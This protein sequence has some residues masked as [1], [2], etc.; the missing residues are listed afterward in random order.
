MEQA[1]GIILVV[2]DDTASRRLIRTVLG[3]RRYHVE[4]AE[5]LEQARRF[6][7]HTVPALVLLDIR[8]RGSDGLELARDIRNDTRL[9]DVPIIAIT[10]QAMKHDRSRILAAGCDAYVS[11]PVDTRSLPQI[12]DSFLRNGRKL[13]HAQQN[14]V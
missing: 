5:D 14:P 11:K 3:S 7:A 13:Q 8:L 6:L 1:S 2:E 9:R 10:A 12:V 4:Q